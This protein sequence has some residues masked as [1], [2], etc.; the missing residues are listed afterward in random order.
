[1]QRLPADYYADP[2]SEVR[3]I[4]PRWV[5][6]GCGAAAAVFLVLGFAAGAVIMHTGL[7]KIMAFFVGVSTGELAPLMRKDVTPAQRQA[8][9]Q[10]LSQLTKN[11]E[12]DKTNLQR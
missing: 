11:L 9:N 10:E 4:F 2:L 5:P 12:T 3:P 6:L 8:L 7:G 1:M